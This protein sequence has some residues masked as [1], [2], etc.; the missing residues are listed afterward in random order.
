MQNTEPE[1]LKHLIHSSNCTSCSGNNECLQQIDSRN[2]CSA[3]S[4]LIRIDVKLSYK[5]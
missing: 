5:L 2:V 4:I 3:E 1:I